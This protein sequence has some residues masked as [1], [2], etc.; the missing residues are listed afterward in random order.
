MQIVFL[1]SHTHGKKNDPVAMG[2][3]VP[4][5]RVVYF[6]DLVI[7]ITTT[8]QRIYDAS[9]SFDLKDADK[10]IALG[11]YKPHYHDVAFTI[12]KYLDAH[13]VSYWNSEMGV[14][15]STTKLSQ[16][17]LMAQAGLPVPATYFSMTAKLVEKVATFPCVVKAI[18]AS[19]GRANYLVK[20]AT[21]L[22]EKCLAHPETMMLV[23]QFIPN[24]ADVRVVCADSR[25]VVMIERRRQSNDTHLNNVS[26]GA[27]ATL[28]ALKD[29]TPEILAD[30]AHIAKIFHREIC[31]IDVIID[32]NA[33]GHYFL[34][35]NA[36]PQL[37]S[38]SFVAEK[39]AA[40]AE[41][42][43]QKEEVDV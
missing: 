9:T 31:G 41:A 37:T 25:A 35:I 33:S 23:Q 11:W 28:L 32:S 26:Q 4:G 34:E 18:A 19:R 39:L 16:M 24:E 6:E 27:T 40:V 3:A 30:C 8:S 14:M 1:G 15:R 38:G 20:S 13:G 17:M 36:L 42:L 21:E 22:Q 7:E 10:V 2:A 29:V 43:T 5:S 12:A